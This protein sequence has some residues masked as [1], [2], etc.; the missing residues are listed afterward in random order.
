VIA[1]APR[2]LLHAERLAL[3]HPDS[4]EWLEFCSPCPF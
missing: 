1:Q 3:R 4:N 2:L